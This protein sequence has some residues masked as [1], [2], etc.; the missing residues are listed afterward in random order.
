LSTFSLRTLVGEVGAAFIGPE[1]PI[2]LVNDAPSDLMVMADRD[3]LFRALTNLVRNSVE[4]IGARP[5]KLACQAV[6]REGEIEILFSDDGPGIA[7]RILP[8]LFETFSGST[9]ADGTGLGL[10][11]CREIMRAHGGEIELMQT[12]SSGSVFRI[13][14]PRHTQPGET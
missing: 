7:P 13:T 1:S 14:L 3:Q 9:K 8:R 10:A 12:G 11:I 4:A 2:T 6:E 5:G